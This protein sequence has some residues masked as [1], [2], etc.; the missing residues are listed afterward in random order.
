MA[1]PPPDYTPTTI[2]K[3]FEL[4]DN[5]LLTLGVPGGLSAVG[6]NKV[7]S[8]HWDEAIACFAGAA[9]VL[10]VIKLGKKLAPKLDQVLDW[11]INGV[12]RSLLSLR[13]DF[14]GLY[15]QQQARLCEEFTVEG[16]NPDRTAIPLLEDVFV[17]LDLSGAILKG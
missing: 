3:V 7:R 1:D 6:L 17:P 14:T 11:G 15:L 8:G 9:V 10:M 13:S 5:K 16:F 12:E 2:E 4:L